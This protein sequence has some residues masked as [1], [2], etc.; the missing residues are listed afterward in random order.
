MLGDSNFPTLG[1]YVPQP[2][3]VNWSRVGFIKP[4]E[5]SWQLRYDYDL[6]HSAC[7]A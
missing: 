1:G 3:L 6:P 7:R 5:K 4:N 2:F